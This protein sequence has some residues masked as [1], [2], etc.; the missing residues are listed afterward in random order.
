MV[1]AGI[2]SWLEHCCEDRIDEIL[3]ISV[4]LI[5]LDITDALRERSFYRAGGVEVRLEWFEE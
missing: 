2:V 5:N 1:R 4:G 3:K